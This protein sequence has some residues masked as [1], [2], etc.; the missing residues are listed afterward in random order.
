MRQC[1]ILTLCFLS[2]SCV[3]VDDKH[4]KIIVPKTINL[5][6][7]SNQLHDTLSITQADS[8][9]QL[10]IAVNKSEH[11]LVKFVPYYRIS[12]LTVTKKFQNDI[13]IDIHSKQRI[14]F[15]D[16]ILFIRTFGVS[17]GFE[18]FNDVN[19]SYKTSNEFRELIKQCS[20][21]IR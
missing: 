17:D 21:Q 13:G 4:E 19:G 10:V 20:K 1:I 15:Q 6:T 9:N 5:I 2:W 3:K 7:L 8:I 16:S 14:V 18:Y 11:E 12:F